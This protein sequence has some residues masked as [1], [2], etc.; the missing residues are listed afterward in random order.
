MKRVQVNKT[1]KLIFLNVLLLSCASANASDVESSFYGSLRLGAD[2][3]DSGT[4]DDAANGRDYL[5]RVGVKAE[6]QLADGLTGV[7]KVEYGLRGDDGVNFNQNQKA[8]MRQIYVG[9]KGNFGT[10]TYGSQTIIWHQYVRSAYFSDGLDS[11]RQGAIRDDDMLQWQKT[12]NNWKFGA[13]IQTEKQDGDSIDQYQLAAQYKNQNL[14]LQAALAA[15]QQGENTGNLYGFRAWYDIS[16]AFTVSAFYHLAEEDFDLYKGNSSGNVRLVSAEESG[17]VGGVTACVD[18]DRSTVGLYGK[19]RQ[20]NNQ[21]H[22]RYAVNSCEIKGDVSSIKVEYIRYFSKKFRMWASF[23]Q[24]DND[25]T[26]LP[27]TGEDMSEAQ[28]GVRFD[29]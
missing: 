8:G 13:A 28:V 5:S 24:L 4:S 6:V 10:V 19:W 26:R 12:Y 16:K 2:Y 29:F 17:K 21:V 25:T 23:E 22:A 27:S 15:D 11:L 20:G 3:V 1:S 18:E 14:K 7:G 9:L